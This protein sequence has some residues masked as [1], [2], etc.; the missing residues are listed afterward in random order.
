M[1]IVERICSQ[2]PKINHVTD[3]I[4]Y[5]KMVDYIKLFVDI[6]YNLFINCLYTDVHS[7]P[8]DRGHVGE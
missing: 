6:I 2:T 5:T 4:A 3:A 8:S 7:S 1:H